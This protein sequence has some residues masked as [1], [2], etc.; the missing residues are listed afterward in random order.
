LHR[1][2]DERQGVVGGHLSPVTTADLPGTE[3]DHRDGATCEGTLLHGASVRTPTGP[4]P[5]PVASASCPTGERLSWRSPASWGSSAPSCPCSPATSW[6][7]APS[8]SGP[9][10]NG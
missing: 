9:S 8:W 7:A 4:E 10:W 1:R 3:P 2:V 5:P 6:W